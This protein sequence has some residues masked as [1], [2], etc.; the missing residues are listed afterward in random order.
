MFAALGLS[1]PA[2]EP[3][4]GQRI[5]STPES[6][7]HDSQK[8]VHSNENATEGGEEEP[9]EKEEAVVA[10]VDTPVTANENANIA[11]IRSD[12]GEGLTLLDG[13]RRL[14]TRLASVELQLT[15]YRLS[16]HR[17]IL[18]VGDQARRCVAEMTDGKELMTEES[19]QFLTAAHAVIQQQSM[20][21]K[22]QATATPVA[23]EG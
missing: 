1:L 6:T 5:E 8:E 19:I 13:I 18:R 9:E 23:R 14:E 22:A 16:S 11:G 21:T 10:A 2:A 20:G 15:D 3:T 12:H 17:Q 7:D 4:V